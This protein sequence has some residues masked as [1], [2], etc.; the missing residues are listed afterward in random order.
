VIVVVCKGG[1]TE[2]N[3]EDD[4]NGDDCNYEDD[5]NDEDGDDKW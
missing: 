3:N 2:V 5:C 4:Y 1:R